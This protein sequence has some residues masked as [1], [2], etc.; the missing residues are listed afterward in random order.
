M[1]LL[2][3]ALHAKCP[4]YPAL[5]M[6]GVLVMQCFECKV[7]VLS[8][9]LNP[10]VGF[11]LFSG[12]PWLPPA[13]NEAAAMSPTSIDSSLENPYSTTIG[14]LLGFLSKEYLIEIG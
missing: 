4:Y 9:A 14:F 12:T 7:S 8:K 11:V 5:Y 6:Q 10:V 3:T 2:F 13:T 1:S